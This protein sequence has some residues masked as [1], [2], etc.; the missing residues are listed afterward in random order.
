MDESTSEGGHGL[1]MRH[2]QDNLDYLED[3]GGV[4]HDQLEEVD[5]STSARKE[6][7]GSCDCRRLSN[8]SSRYRK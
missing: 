1:H 2:R 6:G 8:D 7:N 4:P 3:F 5:A